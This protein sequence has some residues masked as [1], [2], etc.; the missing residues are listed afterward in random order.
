MKQ[1]HDT[2]EQNAMFEQYVIENSDGRQQ[3][4]TGTYGYDEAEWEAF[5]AGWNAAK[6][7]FGVES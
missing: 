1:D 2:I 4:H 5:Q 7:H 6:Q 3:H